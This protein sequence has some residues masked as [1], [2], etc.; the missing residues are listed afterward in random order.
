MKERFPLYCRW[1]ANNEKKKE[2]L[3]T[4]YQK[5]YN[6][7]IV[8]ESIIQNFILYIKNQ[9]KKKPTNQSIRPKM[10]QNYTKK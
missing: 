7:K 2:T 6:K 10:F 8:Q 4:L 1:C 5:I 9:I 3:V